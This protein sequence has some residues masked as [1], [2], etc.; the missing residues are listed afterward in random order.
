M[1]SILS[2]RMAARF[3]TVVA[4]AGLLP[5]AASAQDALPTAEIE[6]IVRD[7]LMREPQVIYDA[8]QELQ[9]RR[10]A[11]QAARQKEMISQRQDEL[12]RAESDPVAGN[13]D[14]DVTV[15]EFF[16][17]R[18][19]YCR[20]MANGLRALI[21]HDP[22]L[23]FVFKEL[24][25]LGPESVTAA[26]A[27]LAAAKLAPEKYTAFH[28]A[29]MQ[30]RDLS[31]EA[32]LILAEKQGYDP[33]GLKAEMDK[34]WVAERIEANLRLASE[35]GIEGTPSFVVGDTLIP[36]AT[37]VANIAALVGEQR[38]KAN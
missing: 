24:P 18:C 38:Q 27:G 26:R 37:D 19:S 5:A 28:F 32:V 20:S 4:A 17:Y 23:R 34:A 10:E 13:P 30:S 36:G 1:F 16:D 3:G 8:I 12:L 11:E 31:E 21:G 35:L 2:L 9:K 14:G 15:V 29:L 22:K 25:V 6:R 7:Y 33:A